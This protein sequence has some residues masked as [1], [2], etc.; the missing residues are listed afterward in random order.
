MRHLLIVSVATSVSLETCSAASSSFDPSIINA[1]IAA[2]A[3]AFFK[4]SEKS[5]G[6]LLD[7][8]VK[9]IRVALSPFFLS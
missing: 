3:L 6:G 8:V 1:S 4:F 7:A 5:T 9:T 2:A